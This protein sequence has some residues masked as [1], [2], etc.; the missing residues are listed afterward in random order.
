M[1]RGAT[2]PTHPSRP[3]ARHLRRLFGALSTVAVA[4]TLLIAV[5]QASAVEQGPGGGGYCP[6]EFSSCPSNGHWCTWYGWCGVEMGGGGLGGGGG[7][8]EPAEPADPANC[9]KNS[10][11]RLIKKWSVVDLGKCATHAI[12]YAKRNAI[13]A[14]SG[15]RR[16]RA[17]CW[18]SH[19]RPNTNGRHLV[20][21][22][23]VN[24]Y[25]TGGLDVESNVAS[26]F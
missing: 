6:A 2:N 12:C 26:G 11:A 7:V 20:F 5:P 3:R 23:P 4:A 1:T 8:D 17:Y 14:V 24:G 15:T 22:S 21:A 18:A 9:G 25:A 19:T 13:N 10:R 16:G